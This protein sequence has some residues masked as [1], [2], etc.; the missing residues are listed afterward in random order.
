VRNIYASV[1]PCSAAFMVLTSSLAMLSCR[2]LGRLVGSIFQNGLADARHLLT[3]YLLSSQV[4]L[5]DFL[6]QFVNCR[7]FETL[8]QLRNCLPQELRYLDS[9][10]DSSYR[11]LDIYVRATFGRYELDALC[12]LFNNGR[13]TISHS[14]GNTLYNTSRRY[15]IEK[16]GG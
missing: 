3:I 14:S 4:C 12:E 5:L 15:L 8:L 13:T 10:C 6:P 11:S 16:S 2:L 9:R 7:L 1:I